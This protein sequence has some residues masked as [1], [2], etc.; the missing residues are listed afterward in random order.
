[1]HAPRLS[2]TVA[3]AALV[4]MHAGAQAIRGE[5]RDAE[6][7]AGLAGAVVEL[8][9][10]AGRPLT[11]SMTVASGRYML[12][13]HGSG[14]Y[15]LRAA[16]IGY[17]PVVIDVTVSEGGA[18]QLPPVTLVA[19][20]QILPDLVAIAARPGCAD[21]D[22]GDGRFARIV[23]AIS[24]GLGVIEATVS[25]GRVRFTTSTVDRQ[26]RTWPSNQERAD[27]TIGPMLAW[28]VRSLA[29]DSLRAIGFGREL[30]TGGQNGWTYYGPDT[31]ALFSDWFLA[32][33]CFTVAEAKDR[34]GEFVV[35]FA[36][37]DPGPRIDLSG[38][39]RV[40]ARRML[41]TRLV[42]QHENLPS[43]TPAGSV[44]GEIEFMKL[45]PTLVVPARWMMY[46]PIPSVTRLGGPN[47]SGRAIRTG[48]LLNIQPVASGEP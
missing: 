38:A 26:L 48:K 11:R 14:A 18:V 2:L 40:D 27:T 23:D 37:R 30:N 10:D 44:G 4:P 1:M 46:A 29:P 42:Y 19:A 13:S 31:G 39:I 20:P 45:G 9:D 33:H 6:T 25:S 35:R 28:P 34:S 16:A 43:G 15:R 41:P 7:G 8:G 47:F 22:A 21:P 12:A 5:V 32:S 24:T 3:I 36:P 17:A